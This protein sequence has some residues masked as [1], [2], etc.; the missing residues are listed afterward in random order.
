VHNKREFATSQTGESAQADAVVPAL[1]R[2]DA[3]EKASVAR[4]ATSATDPAVDAAD[5]IDSSSVLPGMAEHELDGLISARAD[6]I[7]RHHRD[8][9]SHTEAEYLCWRDLMPLLDEK[10]RRLTSRG[11]KSDKNFTAF[12]LQNGLNP[13]TVRSW[14]RRLKKELEPEQEI[15]ENHE[16]STAAPSAETTGRNEAG[17]E[18]IKSGPEL[19]AEHAA[20]MLEVLTGKTVKNDSLRISRTVALVKDLRRAI[21]EGKLFAVTPSPAP[22]QPPPIVGDPVPESEPGTLEELRQRIARMADTDEISDALE[23]FLSRLVAP[24]LEHHAYAPSHHVSVSVR[25]HKDNPRERIS[26][27]DWL[28]YRGGDSRLSDQIGG[29]RSLGRVIGKDMLDRPRVRWYSGSEW[30]KPYSLFDQSSV[31]VLFD[32]QAAKQYPEAFNAYPP[33]AKDKTLPRKSPVDAPITSTVT[34]NDET[35]PEAGNEQEGGGVVPKSSSPFVIV[36]SGSKVTEESDETE[37]IKGCTYI[38]APKG[39]AGEYA[40]LASNPYRGC[41]H[42]CAYCYVPQVVKMKRE[43]FDAGAVARPDFL[44]NLEK[45][46]AKY[47]EAG[48]KGQVMLS[49]T[50]DPYHLGDTTLTRQTIECLQR[51]GMG[52]CTLTKGGTRSLRDLDLFRPSRDAFAS[53]LTSLDDGFSMKW[54]RAAALPGDRIEALKAFHDRGIFTWV[55]LEPTLDCDASLEIVKRTHEYV[56][57]YKIGR[58]NYLP[59]TKTTDWKEYTERMM[60]IC[61]TLKAAHY[62]KRD[63]QQY[64][65]AGYLNVLRHEQHH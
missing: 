37:G 8:A 17:R 24:L 9:D 34:A 28:E 10:Q 29:E 26:L 63:L 57:L 65:P 53:T 60:E 56:D 6:E 31:R 22:P 52:V 45:D 64:L 20:N 43:E 50:T 2:D 55:S 14:R 40:S 12:L 21:D 61:A 27:D 42:G 16:A 33:D 23:E 38:Y 46:A 49:F 7:Q 15:V 25:R 59:M 41:G 32:F 51:Y 47:Q 11:K 30:L 36:R 4:N 44:R 58:V 19:L 13:N 35:A 5:A 3:A 18:E 39:Q 48:Y 1:E 54:E 62:F